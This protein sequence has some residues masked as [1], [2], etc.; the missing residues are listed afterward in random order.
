MKN[1]LTSLLLLAS[2]V[3]ATACKKADNG[4]PA[5]DILG[6]LTGSQQVPAVTSNASGTVTGTYDKAAM[7]LTYTITFQGLSPVGAHFHLG[8]PGANGNIFY[9]IPFNNATNDGYMSPITGTKFFAM[10]QSTA[11]LNHGVYVNLHTN[12]YMGGEIRADLTVN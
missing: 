9:K 10:D 2:L 8:A 4:A 1:F 11:L 7:M 3:T 6:R 5:Q 12:A